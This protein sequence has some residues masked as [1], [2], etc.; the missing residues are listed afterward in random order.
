VNLADRVPFSHARPGIRDELLQAERNLLFVVGLR[1]HAQYLHRDLVAGLEQRGRIR[2]ARPAHLGNVQQALHVAAEVDEHAEL[3]YRRDAPGQ[4]GT[5]HDRFPN[6]ARAGTLFFLE[7]GAARHDQVL[8]PFLELDDAE[9][10]D[11]ADVRRRFRAER[12]DLR[13]R[14]ER[15]LAGD[16]NLVAP[17]DLLLDLAFDGKPGAERVLELP[18][19]RRAARELARKLQAAGHRHDHRLDAIA[20]VDLDVAVLVFELGDVDLRF[21]LA[22]HVDKRHVRADGDD[23]PLDG[24][25]FPEA[26]GLDRG[27]EQRGEI[28]G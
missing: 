12:V 2:D 4:H 23:G 17:L 18:D 22:A 8:P 11:L 24:L 21:P 14:T 15:A 7:Q 25:P 10:V 1:V 9:G 28:L 3:A 6:V 16:A 27:F 20:D 19:G 26:F 5:G 13:E